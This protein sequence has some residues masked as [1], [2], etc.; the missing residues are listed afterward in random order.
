MTIQTNQDLYAR[1]WDGAEQLRGSMDASKYKDYMLGIMF[2]KF[3]SDKTLASFSEYAEI[4]S[5]EAYE[6]YLAADDMRVQVNAA[7]ISTL[8]YYVQP[9]D[10]YQTWIKKIENNTFEVQNIKDAINN[11][12]RNIQGSSNRHDF[13]GLF[14]SMNVDSP[15]LGGD[16]NARNKNLRAL[17][18][19]FAD[20]DMA[21]L[22]KTDVLGD[23][24]EY[25][26]G[27]FGMESG[28]KAGEFYTPRQVSEVMA[29]VITSTTDSI[30]TIYDPTVGSGSLLLTVAKHL[31]T[32]NRTLLR[33]Y[34]QEYNTATFNLT[35][36]NLLLHGVQP[37]HMTINNG[38][39]L[40][41]D[42]P[43]D[44][45]NPQQSKQFDAVVMNPPYSHN[46]S[47]GDDSAYEQATLTDPRYQDYGALAPKTKAD[48]AFL[49]HGL[50]H[51]DNEGTMAIVL[52]HG[53]LFR[54]GDEAMIRQNLLK[55]NQIDIIIGM[56]STLFT[57]TSIP[58][59]VMVLKKNR[60]NGDKVLIIDASDGFVKDGKQNKLRE[61][62]IAKIV[63]TVKTRDEIPGFSHLAS[64]DEIRENDWNLNIPRYVESITQED[65]QD[66]DGH[67]KGGVPAFALENLHV[68]NQLAKAELDASF[69]V[70]RPGYL[71]ANIDK[72][73]LRKSIYQAHEVIASKNAYQTSISAFVEKWFARLINLAPELSLEALKF[74]MSSDA[75]QAL[76]IDD[77]VDQYAAYQ[78]V[79]N[80]WTAFL[81]QDTEL[82]Q[83]FGL[84]QTGQEV[85]TE[86]NNKG[87]VIG[88]NGRVIPKTLVQKVLFIDELQD[89][90]QLQQAADEA[91]EAYNTLV[92]EGQSN[93]DL[94]AYYEEGKVQKNN[95]KSDLKD[96]DKT[97]EDDVLT[98]L[99]AFTA[100]D[101]LKSDA[102]R[103]VKKAA[104]AL[105]EMTIARYANLTEDEV[106]TLL[107]EKWFG[108]FEADM[109]KLLDNAIDSELDQLSTLIDRYSD[110]LQDIQ[111]Q[112]KALEAELQSMMAQLVEG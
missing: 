30:K 91:D 38:D 1:L 69:D 9:E 99:K 105:D 39:T 40:R 61:R 48:F 67:L 12:N 33:Y 58:V 21:E 112:K 54:G 74:E 72:E 71:K 66:V 52:P 50:Y 102:N 57:N 80:L 29:Q 95:I 55:R 19:L 101:K 51:L 106:K 23:A 90:T 44:E 109:I 77:V 36:M 103:T 81:T 5:E 25:L 13:D 82:I 83:K 24:Y 104:E 78:V 63:D 7:L 111:A 53:V 20:L 85:V 60:S 92:E 49:L 37:D 62:D 88:R 89:V 65:V 70:I 34:G 96:Y 64:L 35:R 97:S 8:G 79:A 4:P 3:L 47:K 73:V 27:Q 16:L 100:A 31:D 76:K 15:D 86:T 42:W 26:V 93:A 2:Y 46:W 28:K 56:P 108:S 45:R 87:K 22:Q 68:I 17:I 10:L 41:E 107:L 43:E 59:I 75:Q 98:W 6:Q 32:E 18:K 11:F 94:E 14:S 84:I 110:T